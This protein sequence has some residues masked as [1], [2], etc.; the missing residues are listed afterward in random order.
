MRQGKKEGLIK[1]TLSSNGP[2]AVPPGVRQNMCVLEWVLLNVPLA[3]RV[4]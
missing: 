1:G 4:V 2:A 3:A